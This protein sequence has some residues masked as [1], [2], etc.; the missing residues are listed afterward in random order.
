MEHKLAYFRYTRGDEG[1]CYARASADRSAASATL[2]SDLLGTKHVLSTITS[3]FSRSKRYKKFALAEL[4]RTLDRMR[5]HKSVGL[6]PT[7]LV[8]NA[9]FIMQNES[10]SARKE[11]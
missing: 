5:V 3:G 9:L 6:K 10:T 7:K 1:G 11:G 2:N 8:S 4:D